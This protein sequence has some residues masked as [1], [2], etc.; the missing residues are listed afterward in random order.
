MDI[1]IQWQNLK[2]Q[3]NWM[4]IPL[5][6]SATPVSTVCTASDGLREVWDFHSCKDSYFRFLGYDEMYYC[7]CVAR[8]RN[9]ILIKF[10]LMMKIEC[11]PETLVST[12][13]IT[14]YH[15]TGEHSMNSSYVSMC[16]CTALSGG[17]KG[18]LDLYKVFRT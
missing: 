14:W 4:V 18:S 2:L 10:T 3:W 8:F 5:P 15:N 12:Y 1:F 6:V 16:W 9:N 17:K 11:S 7:R 13:Q